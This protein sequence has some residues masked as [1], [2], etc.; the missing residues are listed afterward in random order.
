M[1]TSVLLDVYVCTRVPVACGSQEKV[2]DPLELGYGH[3]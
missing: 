1:S 3:L 2:L